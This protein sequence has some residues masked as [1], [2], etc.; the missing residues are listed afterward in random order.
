MPSYTTTTTSLLVLLGLGLASASATT[1]TFSNNTCSILDGPA[2][3]TVGKDSGV[4]KALPTFGP[5]PGALTLPV[6]EDY[7]PMPTNTTYVHLAGKMAGGLDWCPATEANIGTTIRPSYMQS[8]VEWGE[9]SLD[10]LIATRARLEQ[11]GHRLRKE[12][13]QQWEAAAAK[14]T[15]TTASH[16]TR[17][18]PLMYR[19]RKQPL[20]L[21]PI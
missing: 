3:F 6:V 10:L 20:R 19:F 15:N 8:I 5:V 4:D 2:L 17:A 1:A 21:L 16:K 12:A 9:Q 11:E 18:R 14:A 13:H 7:C